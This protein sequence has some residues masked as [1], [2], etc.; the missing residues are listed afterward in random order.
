[1]NVAQY[2]DF[3]RGG[4]EARAKHVSSDT[5]ST[6]LTVSSGIEFLAGNFF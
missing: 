2:L 1:M 5:Y 6:K 4:G 3:E